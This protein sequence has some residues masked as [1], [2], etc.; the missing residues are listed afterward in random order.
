MSG[1]A[2]GAA[3]GAATLPAAPP[4][5][6]GFDGGGRFALVIIAALL[7]WRLVLAASVPLVPDEAY[8][9][10]WAQGLSAGYLDHPPMIA[11][12]IRAGQMLAGDTAL[13]VRLACVLSVV[14]ASVFVWRAA[15]LLLDDPRA[16]PLAAVLFNATIFGFLGMTLATPDAPLALFSAAMVYGAARLLR[17]PRPA[18]WLALGVAT[19]LAMLSKYSGAML[20]GGFA[21]AVLA[22]P[23]LRRQLLRAWPWLAL[24]VAVLVCLPNLLWN[25]A[26]G[27][28]TFTKQGGR[29]TAHVALRP[30]FLLEFVGSQIGLATPLVFFFAVAGLLPRTADAFRDRGGR[31]L[32]LVMLLVPL[33]Y[34]AVHALRSR[35]EGNWVGFLYPLIAVAA[36]AGMLAI[37]PVPRR[38]LGGLRRATVPLALGFVLALGVHA[39][40]PVPGLGARD[41]IARMTRGW[42][43]FA[44]EIEALRVRAGAD[45]VL[46]DN[47]QLTAM[48]TRE[49]PGV[50][51]E[52]LDER[53]RY[54]FQN[55]PPLAAR[56]GTALVVSGYRPEPYLEAV[57]GP[58]TPLGVVER[59]FRDV[60]LKPLVRIYTVALPPPA[61]SN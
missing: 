53:A 37:E 28:E 20:A 18:L 15:A 47:Y 27:F 41:P 9:A 32:V 14:P 61:P 29:I 30:E 33:A 60:A 58:L 59:R 43:E 22:V 49:L 11:F 8:Y 54:R 48:L 50:M 51:V 35:V 1:T 3:T 4:S 5:L 39:L 16:G 42:P 12:F 2:G 13:G 36:A 52:Q 19:G 56:T 34:F 25:V 45:L 44:A 6:P 17:A 23:A 10:L 57:L 55:L 24:A 26:H 31:R 7:V 21:L 46:A 38:W 40:V